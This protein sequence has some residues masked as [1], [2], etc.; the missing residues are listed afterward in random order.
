MRQHPDLASELADFFANQEEVAQLAHGMAGH[1][2]APT[3]APGATSVLAAGT[4]LRYFGDYELL[5][6]IARGGMGVVYKARQVS[7]NRL[8][9][10][11]MILAGQLA[12][13]QDVQR[14]RTEA[15]AAANLDHPHILP[16][17]EVGEH[18][19][20]HYFSMKLIDGS[21]LAQRQSSGPRPS[22]KEAARLLAAVARAVHYAHQRGILHRDL[23]PA[24]ILLD[25]AGQPYVADFGLAK[26]VE[27]DTRLTH[28]GVI[29]GT[30]SYMAPEQARAEKALSTA[31]DTYSLG[32]ILYEL[33][34]DKP[35]FKGLTPLDTILQVLE[36][37]PERPRSLNP[38][39]D[40]DLETICL[41]CLEKDPRRR[42]CS[43]EA[44]AEDLEGWLRGEP[45][46]AR[47]VRAPVRLW[48]W[49][50]RSPAVASLLVALVLAFLVGF[51]GI[52]WQW[53]QA[54]WQRQQAERRLAENYLDRGRTLCEQGD[55]GRGMLWL[56]RSLELA[57]ADLQR[58]IRLNLAI[59]YPQV[60]KLRAILEHGTVETSATGFSTPNSTPRPGISVVA[61]SPDGSRILTKETV[62]QLWDAASGNPIG[63]PLYDV[64][65]IEAIKPSS[66]AIGPT[67]GGWIA[68]GVLAA[69][70]GDDNRTLFTVHDDGAIRRWDTAKRTGKIPVVHLALNTT[71]LTGPVA[72]SPDGKLVLAGQRLL[73]EN[74]AE[75]RLWDVATGKRI[76]K[77][78]QHPTPIQ[79]AVFSPEGH[80]LVIRSSDHSARLWDVRAGEPRGRR[81]RH[82]GAVTA[83]TFSPDGK[84]V[85]TASRDNTAR[86]W[87]AATC[88]AIGEPLKHQGPVVAV[89]YSPDGSRVVSGSWDRTARVWDA[90]TGKPIGTPLEHVQQVNAVVFRQDGAA[91]LTGCGGEA[92]GDAYLHTSKGEARLWDLATLKPIGQ[93]LEH[94]G[95]VV[96]VALSPDGRKALTGNQINGAVHLWDVAAG[97][98]GSLSLRH[99][100]A[101]LTVEFGPDGRRILTGST[102]EDLTRGPK[103][104]RLWDA[105]TGK[106]VGSW[107]QS[108]ASNSYPSVVILSPDGSKLLIR[109]DLEKTIQLWDAITGKPVGPPIQHPDPIQ[110]AVFSSDSMLFLSASGRTA[111]IWDCATG[112]LLGHPLR[113]QDEIQAAAFSPDGRIIV[114]GGGICEQAHNRG[115]AQL[116]EAATGTPLGAPLPHQGRVA[117][118]AFSP[119]GKTMV[120]AS[121]WYVQQRSV[122]DIVAVYGFQGEARLWDVRSGRLIGSPLHSEHDIW[123]VAYSPDGSRLLATGG[124]GARL[125][126]TAKLKPVGLPFQHQDRISSAR[127]SGDGRTVLT[128]SDGAARL[129]D[130]S[131]GSPIGEP[132]QL[133]GSYRAVAFSPDCRTVLTGSGYSAQLW[134]V[135]TGQRIGP[136]LRQAGIITAVAFSPDQE[137]LAIASEQAVRVLKLPAPV[138]GEPGRIALWSNVVT[139]MEIGE[140]GGV[141]VLDAKTWRER[142]I[143]LEELGGP[144]FAG[145]NPFHEPSTD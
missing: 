50:R 106:P 119:D 22:A 10:L 14:F 131:T 32:A 6:E 76:G 99:E 110:V 3:L 137:T 11:K 71:E 128:R 54:V 138:G 112:K 7:L 52:A 42:Y 33:L 68:G 31:V 122:A 61:F 5:E 9:A 118:V 16:I 38:N 57:P 25:G 130:A 35:P 77:P 95:T 124:S 21:N 18:D 88:K 83:A 4:K 113:H 53:R 116:W 134:H 15:E 114:T 67:W 46:A 69:R 2:E 120:T 49:C 90:V 98:F 24:N 72:F 89:A 100:S 56:A 45:I 29:V 80:T 141:V 63:G 48:R 23:K 1:A 108:Q 74:R 91:I 64:T 97:Q 13:P 87:D 40:R 81:L 127:F 28:S 132:F 86:I 133:Q 111:R 135:S 39:I 82:A 34:T 123:N 60:N 93:A 142:R 115:E 27:G 143:R 59:W 140:R 58:A 85:V 102:N 20:Q 66:P 55:T 109:Q 8:V 139:G 121:Y 47:P 94:Q 79:A 92:F 117:A 75:I 145:R 136:V 62:A 43:A 37:E 19:G 17:Y 12:S 144:P 103:S 84:R 26:R 36:K 107:F 41:K 104:F 51:I 125:L 65:R 44:L 70:F 96:A 73:R 30:P 78:L 126:D 101:V 105:S 129:W